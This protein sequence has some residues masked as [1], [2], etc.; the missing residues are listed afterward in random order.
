LIDYKRDNYTNRML[1]Y[2][3]IFWL[4]LISISLYE[5]IKLILTEKNK[6]QL[7]W[8]L[9]AAGLLTAN[10][11]ISY[12]R[13]DAYLNSHSYASSIHDL[14]A[15]N[16]INTDAAGKDYIV[17]ANQQVSAASLRQFG[18]AKYY[19]NNVFY[20][21]IPTGGPLYQYY[22][23]LVK[24]PDLNTIKSAGSLVGVNQVYVV[25]NEYW[26]QARRLITELDLLADSHQK[27]A[28]GK[29]HVFKFTW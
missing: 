22:L 9:V 20:Y 1:A 6:T 8:A 16:W 7:T 15:V 5:F 11:Y 4:P 23:S 2:A 26:W 19:A 14:E 29:V 17:L 28:G 12:P 21:P 18:F 10:L 24:T 25:I 13:Q 3:I 27:I